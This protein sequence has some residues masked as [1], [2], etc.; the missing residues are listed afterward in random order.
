[1]PYIGAFSLLPY[2]AGQRYIVPVFNRLAAAALL[3]GLTLV[4]LNY[5]WST[6]SIGGFFFFFFI[7]LFESLWSRSM[8]QIQTGDA[9]L[10]DN[11]AG[12]ISKITHKN[13]RF[14][15]RTRG[16]SHGSN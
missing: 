16:F 14:G 6:R 13:R 8:K 5:F 3:G 12:R 4:L 9:R 15:A 11:G 1:M 7:S 10:K 2:M